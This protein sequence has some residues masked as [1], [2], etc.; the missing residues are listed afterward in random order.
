MK[1]YTEEGTIVGTVAYMS[2]EQAEGKPVDARSDIFSFGSLL[3]EMVTGRRAFQGESKLATLSAILRHEPPPVSTLVEEM[4]PELEKLIQRCLRKDPERRLQHLADVK[5]ALE[6]LKE[7]SDSGRLAGTRSGVAGLAAGRKLAWSIGLA[8]VV[9]VAGLAAWRFSQINRPPP[10]APRELPLTSS[11]GSEFSPSFSPDGK[12]VAFSWDGEKQDNTD[13]YIKLIGAGDPL[14]LTKDPAPDVSPAWSPDGRFIAFVRTRPGQKSEILAV[15]ALGGAERKLGEVAPVLDL[16]SHALAWTPDSQAL[17]TLDRETAGGPHCLFL[18][19]VQSGERRKL[20]APPP[21]ARGDGDPAI[22]PDGSG[23]AFIR[24]LGHRI[25]D[26]YVVQLERDYG[27]KGELKRLTSDN[28]E[29]SSPVWSADGRELIFV[30]SRGG[31]RSLWRIDAAGTQ[32]PTPLAGGTQAGNEIAISRQGDRLA[33]ARSSVD[34]DIW[35]LDLEPAGAKP[36]PPLKLISS[37]A[38]DQ[39]PS[40]SPDGKRIVF[41]SNRTGHWEIWVCDSEGGNPMQLTFSGGPITYAPSWSPAGN[42]IAFNTRIGA[43]QDIFVVS[44]NGG[45][46]RRL[47]SDPSENVVAGWSNDGRWVYFTS[48]RSGQFQIWK[49]PAAGGEAVQVTRSGGYGPLESPDGRFVYYAKEDGPTSLWR[50]PVE[51]G[52]E[53][54]VLES[55]YFWGNFQVVEDGI[56]YI[57]AAHSATQHRVVFYRF[58]DGKTL[59]VATAVQNPAGLAVSPDRKVL[60]YAAAESRGSDLVLLENFR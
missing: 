35:R 8:G 7:E 44:A 6:E 46:P 51:G 15:P 11:P 17:I 29:T 41:A 23:L 14:R 37:T 59:D 39:I 40:F 50:V 12:Q 48:N 21:T 19:G 10:A 60:L 32:P 57:P 58:A 18:L 38:L 2:P 25:S 31:S 26:L 28:L 34:R 1:P 55:L 24:H 47:T 43:K 36:R 9:L 3:Y 16:A 54:Q 5:L 52:E 27:P 22:S 45:K 20:T 4:P 49:A 42:E 53:V 56:Y 33:Y 30:S 13:V